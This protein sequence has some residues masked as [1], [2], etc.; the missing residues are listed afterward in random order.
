MIDKVTVQTVAPILQKFIYPN[1]WSIKYHWTMNTRNFSSLQV[2]QSIVHKCKSLLLQSCRKDFIGF[3]CECIVDLKGNLQSIKR[4]HITKFHNEVRLLSLR[5]LTWKQR[6]G[7]LVWKESLKLKKFLLLRSVTICLDMEQFFL[8][9]A[10]VY[11]NKN[12]N[13]QAVT[14]Q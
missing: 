12:L 10:S 14:E 1:Q 13:I 9:P 2:F 7:A 11:N 8:V 4:H 3:L 5:R 6:R